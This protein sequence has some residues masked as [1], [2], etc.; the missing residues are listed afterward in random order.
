MG[1]ETRAVRRDVEV[2]DK[3]EDRVAIEGIG[4]NEQVIIDSSRYVQEEDR[5]KINEDR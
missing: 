2:L 1:I 5:I 4:K 3:N